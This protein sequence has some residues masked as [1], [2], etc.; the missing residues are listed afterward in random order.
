VR[1]PSW[2]SRSSPNITV[3][4]AANGRCGNHDFCIT[5]GKL[6][7]RGLAEESAGLADPPEP[8]SAAYS[9]PRLL[10]PLLHARHIA[11]RRRPPSYLGGGGWGGG[12]PGLHSAVGVLGS[13]C[14]CVPHACPAVRIGTLLPKAAPARPVRPQL[15]Q[16][17]AEVESTVIANHA[18]RTGWLI[19]ALKST[20]TQGISARVLLGPPPLGRAYGLRSAFP[21]A[22]SSGRL[23]ILTC[24]N[25]TEQAAGRRQPGTRLAAAWLDL[26]A[27]SVQRDKCIYRD[28]APRHAITTTVPL[29][30][31]HDIVCA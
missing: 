14:A 1:V 8:R 16:H 23:S 31:A 26:C 29:R 4:T 30:I 27:G 9:R 18:V 13:P 28:T 19:I 11:R 10:K 7:G 15:V 20:M 2:Y 3:C 12:G 25:L 17:V 22:G 6:V 24:A 5:A 21:A